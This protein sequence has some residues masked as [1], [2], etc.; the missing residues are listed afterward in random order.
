[1]ALG[2]GHFKPTFF[3]SHVLLRLPELEC[4][5]EFKMAAIDPEHRQTKDGMLIILPEWAW[6][7]ERQKAIK[8]ARDKVARERQAEGR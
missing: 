7:K 2:G 3:K 5:P 8:L 1:M 6:N 4:A